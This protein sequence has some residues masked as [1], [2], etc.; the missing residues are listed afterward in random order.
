MLLSSGSK[1]SEGRPRAELGRASRF[2]AGEQ[3]GDVMGDRLA[4]L[5]S[6]VE[7][8]RST[9]ESLKQRI[10]VLEAAPPAVSSL[11]ADARAG[12]PA[13]RGPIHKSPSP[14]K[15][16]RYDP[17][18]VLSLVGRLFLV[19]AGG[20]FLRAMT[21][22]GLLSPQVGIAL[23]FI[24]GLLWLVLAD[25]AGRLGLES[26]AV[27]HALSTA[28]VVF[29]L[30]VEAATRFKVLTGAGS[31]FGLVILTAA[32]LLVGWRQHLRAIAWVA[33]LAA[34]PTSLVL[35]A[36]AGVIVP[37]AIYLIALGGTTLWLGHARGWTGICW[38]VALTADAV[39]V[40]VTLRALSPDHL[41]AYRIALVLQWSLLAAY[42][43]GVAVRTLVRGRSVALFEIVQ[44]AAALMIAFVG[45]SMLTQ[46]TGV[47][48]PVIGVISLAIGAACYVVTFI[49][50]E[51]RGDF[52]RNLYFYSTLALVLV[53]AGFALVTREHWAAAVFAA[54][55][56]IAVRM[57]SRTGWLYLLLHGAAYVVAASFAS[58]ALRYGAWALVAS[59][60]GPWLLPSAVVLVMLLAGALSA[61][62]A[63]TR[64]A[65]HGGALASGLRLIIVA[66]LAWVAC[67]AVIG[68][69]APTAAGLADRS[70]DLGALATLRTGVL[71]V[72]AL[73][74]AWAGRQARFREWTWLVYPL[75]V[76]IGLKM[77]AQDFKVSRPA[78]LFIALALYGAALIIAPRLRRGG[79]KARVSSGMA[80]A[81]GADP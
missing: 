78:T 68:V 9:V 45:T 25:R 21:E 4:R 66:V 71:A 43:V 20:F 19:L 17:I 24:Y 37:I 38:P 59:P 54:L 65:P 13:Q 49:F 55:A 5:E 61:W 76:V 44:V 2:T 77:V 40:G 27:V 31:T 41:D 51:R 28:M 1:S 46:A 58:Q 64:P 36:R 42:F 79:N 80:Q 60:G 75:L 6:T 72:A 29:P 50:M 70:V 47:L 81:V 39:V 56:V 35:L 12:I 10:D 67:G 73:V 14:A 8:L 3:W 16:D 53:V 62:F 69:L 48:P 15:R 26:S 11:A 57:W 23:A 32:M 74:I 18:A 33:I 34:L 63:G 22:A 30:L 52:D 7:Q